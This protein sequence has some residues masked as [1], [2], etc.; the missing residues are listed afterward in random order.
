MATLEIAEATIL[1]DTLLTIPEIQNHFGAGNA[2]RI[3]LLDAPPEIIMPYIVLS[4]MAGGDDNDAQSQASTSYWRV[5]AY[6]TDYLKR[7]D[8]A[9]AI[10]K[11]HRMMP[12]SN[13]PGYCG[14]TWLERTAPI[15]ARTV[16]Q[17]MPVYAIG[18]IFRIR[19]S[20]T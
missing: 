20:I 5:M 13:V 3:F 9:N 17:N 8:I 12:V 10:G 18:A 14:Y 4:H 16:V 1:R 11:M 7:V 15:M 2:G 6:T 19:L